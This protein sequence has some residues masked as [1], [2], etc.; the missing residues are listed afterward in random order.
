MLR[1][2]PALGLGFALLV[3]PL[4]LAAQQQ[5]Q[6]AVRESVEK[7][8]S[9]EFNGAQDPAQR[10]EL[11]HFS[12]DR[13]REL[14]TVMD[15]L[16]PY[17]F[18][19]EVSPLGVVDS[20][21]IGDISVSHG[22]AKAIVHFQVVAKRD[23][24]GGE[25]KAANTKTVTDQLQLKF[26]GQYWKVIDPPFPRVSKAFLSSSYRGMFELPQAWYQH[27]SRAQLLRLRNAID[28]IILLEAL[29]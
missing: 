15:G 4:F 14:R 5:E 20:Y 6:D 2:I 7:F 12:D 18:E 17:V 23:S 1:C 26:D 27:A 9:F 13:L 21:S 22:T 3:G 8:C 29:K 19:W 24:W 11:V 16:S 10:N 28:T 25:I